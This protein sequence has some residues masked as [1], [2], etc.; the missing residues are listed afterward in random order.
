MFVGDGFGSPLH[1][2]FGGSFS[3]ES[4]RILTLYRLAVTHLTHRG[5]NHILGL[6]FPVTDLHVGVAGESVAKGRKKREK[7]GRERRGEERREYKLSYFV[8]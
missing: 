2:F 4:V 6:L 7:G 3:F 5:A 8:G 1:C